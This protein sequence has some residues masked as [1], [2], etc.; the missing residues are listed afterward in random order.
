MSL[1]SETFLLSQAILALVIIFTARVESAEESLNII[2]S[3]TSQT[4]ETSTLGKGQEPQALHL[5][6]PCGEEHSGFCFNGECTYPPDQDLP[7]CRCLPS[8][9]GERCEHVA[10]TTQ[11]LS[12]PE[13]IIAV[14]AGVVLLICCV[15]GVTYCCIRKRCQKQSLPYKTYASENS[16]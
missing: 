16:V 1:Q 10:L 13:E 11:G 5:I 6:R 3:N 14:V 4:L 2:H 7:T 12:S 9:S 15:V 8:Y